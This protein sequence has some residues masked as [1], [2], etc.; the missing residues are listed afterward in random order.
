M[1]LRNPMKLIMTG[2]HTGRSAMTSSSTPCIMPEVTT[3]AICPVVEG[4]ADAKTNGKACIINTSC[5]KIV[6]SY[7]KSHMAYDLKEYFKKLIDVVTEQDN[8]KYNDK[9]AYGLQVLMYLEQIVMK[10]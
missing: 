3:L 6:S 7:I 9:T 8:K 2:M 5:K 1:P 10:H 4:V